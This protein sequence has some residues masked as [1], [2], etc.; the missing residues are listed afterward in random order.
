MV[1]EYDLLEPCAENEVSTIVRNMNYGCGDGSRTT[2]YACFCYQSSAKYSRMISTRVT[3]A[4]TKSSGQENSALEVF[5]KYCQ[6]ADLEQV[7]TTGISTSSE[8]TVLASSTNTN[9]ASPVSGPATVTVSLTGTPTPQ[10]NNMPKKKNHNV[11]IVTGVAV[12]VVVIALSLVGVAIYIHRR[13]KTLSPGELPAESE[14][15][16]MPGDPPPPIFEKESYR[17]AYEKDT[18]HRYEMDANGE[19]RGELIGSILEQNKDRKIEQLLGNM[20]R[21]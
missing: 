18:D 17:H 7:T 21:S 3:S 20:D 4:C 13:K 8:P 6:L 12:P 15:K 10:T 9:S 16:E 2:S 14:R 19:Q 1:P 11:A 5:S